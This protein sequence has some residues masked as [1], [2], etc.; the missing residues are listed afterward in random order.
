MMKPFTTIAVLLLALLALVHIFRF[1]RGLEIVVNG[2]AIPLWI[3]GLVAVV[4]AILALMVWRE[5][6]R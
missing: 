4:A 2:H 3:S 6:K 1:V 5:S